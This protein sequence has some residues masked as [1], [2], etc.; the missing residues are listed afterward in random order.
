MLRISFTGT[1]EGMNDWQRTQIKTWLIDHRGT[2]LSAAHGCCV[3]AD[4]QFHELVREA[5]GRDVLI[6]VFPSTA[7]TAAPIP[8]D[9]NYVHHQRLDPLIRNKLIIDEG[10]DVLL[11]APRG[12]EITRSGTWA[13]IRYARKKKMLIHIFIPKSQAR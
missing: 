8:R 5:L 2:V 11:A 3:G 6:A 10:P 4:V 12:P 9:S 7:K 1:R 13:A